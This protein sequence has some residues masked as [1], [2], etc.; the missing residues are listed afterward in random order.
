MKTLF[1]FCVLVFFSSGC[2]IGPDYRRPEFETPASWRIEETEAK[3]VANTIW[4]DQFADPV[5]NELIQIALKENDD[6]KVATARVEEFYGQYS[7]TR[8]NL[9]PQVGYGGSA[10]RQSPTQN[11]FTPI[12]PG[13]P[14]TYNMYQPQFN[15]SWELDL[16]GQLRRATEAARADLMGT[17]EARRGVILS[18]VASV[19]SSYINLR[20]LD[21]QLEIAQH[22]AKNYE[23]TLNLFKLR[24][25]YGTISELELNQIASQYYSAIA[26][27]PNFETAIAQ[28]EDALNLLLGRNPGTIPRG[29]TIKEITVPAIP[30]GL[31]SDL[32]VRRPDIRQAEQGLIAANARIGVAKGQYF[33]TLSLTALYGAAST[34]LSNLWQ[35]PS[36]IWSWSGTLAG[37]IFTFGRIEGSVRAAKAVQQETLFSYRK[38][39]QNGFRE[40]NDALIG[41][42]RTR[43]Q[44]DAQAK[45]VEALRNYASLAWLRYDNGYVSYL[46]V[47]DAESRLFSGEI[48]YIQV[49]QSLLD[50]YI[51]LYKAMGGGWVTEADRMSTM[52]MAEP[53]PAAPQPSKH[54]ESSSSEPRDGSKQE[55]PPQ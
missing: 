11:G 50:A 43:V 18:L 10:S 3:D 21:Q 44:V 37:P 52:T 40:V 55:A 48:S 29:K 25:Q 16:W 28:Q 9:F 5:L 38:A 6:L 2:A 53:Q 51:N 7:A 14:G 20:S 15:A 27:I 30:T 41:Q 33:P 22:T 12:P 31:P 32:L 49:Q 19:A 4:W 1:L 13:L 26:A 35:G 23:E 17:E 42:N 34:E 46:E 45:Q 54:A 36:R 24:F 47:L 39:I 8:G